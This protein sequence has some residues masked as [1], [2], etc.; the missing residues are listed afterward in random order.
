ML[1]TLSLTETPQTSIKF[2]PGDI[3][4]ALGQIGV[5]IDVLRS[6]QTDN[7]CIYIRFIHNLGNARPYDMLEVS[8]Q[9]MLGTDK[10]TLATNDDLNRAITA[11]RNRLDKEISELLTRASNDKERN[12]CHSKAKSK[13]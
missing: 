12:L 5:I 6:A 1:N 4:N 9:R 7:T 8:P 10:W 13:S 3:I 11:R 2:K